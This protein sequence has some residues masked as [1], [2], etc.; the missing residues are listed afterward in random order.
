MARRLR[1]H[2]LGGVVATV[3]LPDGTL[4]AL[5]EPGAPLEAVRAVA[6]FCDRRG[7]KLVCVSTPQTIY[8]D[9][10]G[11]RRRQSAAYRE[12]AA[13]GERRSGQSEGNSWT[14]E[15]GTLAQIG[16]LDLL[17]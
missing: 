14:P 9:V 7:A 13:V 16:R 2:D 17:S 1:T 10:T 12:L 15:H 5:A 3:R 6:A 11:S 8:T 4:R